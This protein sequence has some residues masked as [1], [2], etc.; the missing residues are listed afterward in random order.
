MIR[1]GFSGTVKEII[2]TKII[3]L[4]RNWRVDQLAIYKRG[5]GVK[6][7]YREQLQQV[8]NLGPSDF[9]SVALT[10]R[11]RCLHDPR[12]SVGVAK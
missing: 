6:L 4:S 5:R 2:E 9:N 10:T 8:L 12:Y 7:V 11:P 3:G 1:R